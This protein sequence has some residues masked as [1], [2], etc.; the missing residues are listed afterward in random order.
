MYYVGP[1]KSL[2]G[3]IRQYITGKIVEKAL[4]LA[5]LVALN[6]SFDLLLITGSLYGSTVVSNRT[7]QAG[8]ARR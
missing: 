8:P 2:R 5:S 1:G 6:Y 4:Y 3:S 7:D